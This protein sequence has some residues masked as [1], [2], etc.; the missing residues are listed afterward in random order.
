MK[1]NKIKTKDLDKIVW[2][3]FLFSLLNVCQKRLFTGLKPFLD[4]NGLEKM[5]KM[6][7]LNSSVGISTGKKTTFLSTE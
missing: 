3:F 1:I 6:G 2:I 5:G 7:F 4:L